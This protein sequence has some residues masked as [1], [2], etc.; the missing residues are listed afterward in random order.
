VEDN[1]VQDPGVSTV[2]LEE[3]LKEESTVRSNTA[4]LNLLAFRSL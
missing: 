3:K 4:A 1:N 2:P